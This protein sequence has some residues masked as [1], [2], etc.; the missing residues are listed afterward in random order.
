[1][2]NTRE[3]RRTWVVSWMEN[4]R[5]YE[6]CLYV[7]ACTRN[8]VQHP[9]TH[10]DHHGARTCNRCRSLHG[11]RWCSGSAFRNHL[12]W[13][14]SERAQGGPRTQNESK[15]PTDRRVIYSRRPISR[16]RYPNAAT[17]PLVLDLLARVSL[18]TRPVIKQH[19][20]RCVM[21]RSV[22]NR[23]KKR[24]RHGKTREWSLSD[25]SVWGVLWSIWCFISDNFPSLN[26]IAM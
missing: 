18:V 8:T 4:A 20:P 24:L 3:N 1:M 5:L 12:N 17:H 11:E 2:M 23:K 10:V 16:F 25:V 13:L 22:K 6:H 14:G 9:P 26:K 19:V 7:C 15:R 21:V